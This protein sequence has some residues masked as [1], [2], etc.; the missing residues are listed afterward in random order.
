MCAKVVRRLLNIRLRFS[1]LPSVATAGIVA[2]GSSK[3]A[4][5]N[6]C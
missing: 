3:S 2:C 6:S 4:N 5:R 1:A